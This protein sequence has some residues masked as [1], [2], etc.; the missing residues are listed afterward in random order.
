MD[1]NYNSGYPGSAETLT[2]NCP[3]GQLQLTNIRLIYTPDKPTAE[4]RNLDIPIR[5]LQNLQVS[6]PLFGANEWTAVLHPVQGRGVPTA[7]TL[8]LTFVTGGA[9]E[10]FNVYRHVLTILPPPMPA[11]STGT[12]QQQIPPLPNYESTADDQLVMQAPNTTEPSPPPY[13]P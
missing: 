6:Q 12:Q 4:L 7:G 2:L 5:Y 1:S 9:V 11:P 13:Q 8:R 3:S 10:L